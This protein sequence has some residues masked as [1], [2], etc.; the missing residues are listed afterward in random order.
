MTLGS[1]LDEIRE[2]YL[3]LF[4][5]A[6]REACAPKGARVLPEPSF[7]TDDGSLAREGS[8]GLP[9]RMD[10]VVFTGETPENVSV[11][12]ESLLTFDALNFDWKEVP[13]CVLPF[14]WDACPVLLTGLPETPDWSPL[15]A[16]F[17][18]WFDLEDARPADK[19]GLYGVVHFLSDPVTEDGKTRFHLDLGSAPVTAFEGLLDALV[20]TGAKRLEF[21]ELSETEA[22]A[23]TD[24]EA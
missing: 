22:E 20:A 19:A 18:Q 2:V 16:W 12:S 5:Q 4:R 15:K 14:C 3:S 8:L 10:V 11:D 21:G 1:V 6:V 17:E 7:L 13:V 24:T 23:G 9:S